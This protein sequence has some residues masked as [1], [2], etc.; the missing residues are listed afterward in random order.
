MSISWRQKG[1]VVASDAGRGDCSCSRTWP[2]FLLRGCSWRMSKTILESV[3]LYSCASSKWNFFL[4]PDLRSDLVFLLPG[5]TAQMVET[6]WGGGQRLY[7][8]LKCCA[9]LEVEGE[10]AVA[11]ASSGLMWAMA[12]SLFACWSW[13]KAERL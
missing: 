9:S 12:S 4:C 7:V 1:I 6:N 11:Q 13:C 5:C 3:Y 10:A 8:F 2:E